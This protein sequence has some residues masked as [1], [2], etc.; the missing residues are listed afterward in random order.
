MCLSKAAR[1]T[2]NFSGRELAKLMA[3]CQAAAYGTA[4]AVLTDS[5][6]RNVLELKLKQH[7]MRQGLA[8][9]AA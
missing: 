6:F 5:L 7:R 8:A 1:E 3:S 4:D 9:T 2:T